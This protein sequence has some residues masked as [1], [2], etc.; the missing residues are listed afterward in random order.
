MLAFH[1]APS[2]GCLPRKNP[3]ISKIQHR[4]LD[5]ADGVVVRRRARL[6]RPSGRAHL[7]L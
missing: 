5:F 7:L 4:W 6:S 2:D 3:L 1:D